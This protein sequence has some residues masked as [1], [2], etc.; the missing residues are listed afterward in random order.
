MLLQFKIILSPLIFHLVHSDYED[1]DMDSITSDESCN[2]PD[3]TGSESNCYCYSQPET[4][5]EYSTC[6]TTTDTT[7]RDAT[8]VAHVPKPDKNPVPRRR[9]IS[10]ITRQTTVLPVLPI[11]VPLTT[12]TPFICPLDDPYPQF[13]QY[14]LVQGKCFYFE[15]VKKNFT[16]ARANCKQKGG[17]LYEPTDIPQLKQ[18]SKIGAIGGGHL[19]WIGITDIAMEGNYV[20]DSNGQNINFSPPWR[21]G[22]GSHGTVFNCIAVFVNGNSVHGKLHDYGCYVKLYSICEF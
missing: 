21:T 12:T 13:G 1:F 11:M 16:E 17:K 3:D 22:Y 5:S 18:V 6:A 9:T 14:Q 8:S 19:T 10:K 15:K 7:T 20:Y 4:D 2:K